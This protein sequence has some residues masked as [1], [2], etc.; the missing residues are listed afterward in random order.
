MTILPRMVTGMLWISYA[1][2]KK[3]GKPLK[4]LDHSKYASSD[5]VFIMAT[6]SSINDYPE[7]RWATIRAHNS[8]GM[9]FFLLYDHVP[10]YYVMENMHDNHR[11]LLSIRADDH[12][13]V[14]LI[15]S[16]Q[17]GNLHFGRLEARLANLAQLERGVLDR[18]YLSLDLLPDGNKEEEMVRAYRMFERVGLFKVRRRFR[19]LTKRRGSVT[20]LINLAVRIGYE[21]IVLC[22][23]DLNHSEYFYD[24]LRED[25]ESRG[26]PVPPN[27]QAGEAHDTNDPTIKPVT[28]KTVILKL[29]ELVLEPRGIRLYCGDKSSD[30][31]PDLDEYPWDE[32][33]TSDA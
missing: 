30:L 13:N 31:F 4:K 17:V 6:G 14:P 1:Y 21:K 23:V 9:N 8:I 29:N 10:T 18:T 12:A 28:V 25:L 33:L 20:H 2:A 16:A 5:T 7:S 24:P 27:R 11:K 19:M 15:L 22:G 3:L 32:N 26:L